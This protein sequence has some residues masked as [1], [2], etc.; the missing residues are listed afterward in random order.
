M[1]LNDELY[2]IEVV[3]DDTYTFSSVGDQCYDYVYNPQ[4]LT[5]EDFFSVFAVKIQSKEKMTRIAVIGSLCGTAENCVI[6]NKGVLLVLQ[7]DSIHQIDV[8]TGKLLFSKNIDAFGGNF[9]IH[10]IETGYIIHG[11]TEIKK[12]NFDLDV[13]LGF[14]ARDI[15][16][17]TNGKA[18][19]ELSDDRIK[20]YDFENNYYEIDFEGQLMYEKTAEG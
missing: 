10:S 15:F 3:M 14:S 18:A 7:N 13:E 9:T 8:A 1:V 12:L 11:E 17:T 6:L 16:A 19:F 5:E 4:H 20:L 2:E